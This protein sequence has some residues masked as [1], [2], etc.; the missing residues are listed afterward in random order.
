MKASQ[1]NVEGRYSQLKAERGPYLQRA[2]DA[3]KLTLPMLA[4][5]ETT[6][7]VTKVST[8]Y[9][10][11]GARGVNNLASKLLMALLPPNSPFFRLHVDEFLLEQEGSEEFK[12]ELETALGKVERAIMQEIETSSDRVAIFEALKHLIVS[13]N[14]LLY[15]GEDGL[16]VFT[17]GRFGIVRDPMGNPLEMVTHEQVSPAALEPEF[18]AKLK[19]KDD[20]KDRTNNEKVINIY[21]QIIRKGEKWEVHQEALG[22]TIPG[23]KGSYPLDVCPWI[24]L[25]FNRIDG[26]DYGRGYVEEYLGDLKSLEGLTKAVV[27]GSAAAAKVLILVNPNG[28]TRSK[29][30]ASAPNLAVREGNADDVSVMQ[31]QKF[32]DFRTAYQA[33]ERIEQRLEFAFLLNTSIQR[34]GERVTAEEIR[35]MAGELEDAL[36]GVYSILSQEFQ[37][38][39]VNRRRHMLT[40]DG[41]L[42]ELPKDIIKPSI[43]TGLEA[44]GRGHDR[45]KLI[46]F[47]STLGQTLGPEALQQYVHADEAIARLAVSDGIDPLGLIK[48]K[49][50]IQAEMQQAQMQQMAQSL[51]PE[52][53]KQ[54]GAAAQAGEAPAPE[55]EPVDG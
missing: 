7:K 10:G 50:E 54:M 37:L 43:V 36:G 4:P 55:G 22:E 24:P 5:H 32:H 1:G 41:R 38:K 11:V 26:E 39:Y 28:T 29:T 6:T 44:L 51:G 33:M 48:T 35:F 16:R 15:V 19:T 17:L 31:M 52:A 47:F 9:Q 21:T 34:K 46:S 20:Y 25:R 27:D 23:S 13:G 2:K 53:M 3:A 42:P 49:E 45:N 8:P 18:L 14:V 12:T 30:V 40:R